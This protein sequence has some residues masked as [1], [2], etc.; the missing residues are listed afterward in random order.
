M[1]FAYKRLGPFILFFACLSLNTAYANNSL[2]SLFFNDGS[3]ITSKLLIHDKANWSVPLGPNELVVDE[4]NVKQH[5]NPSNIN[6]LHA[7][8]Y[9]DA[10][11]SSNTMDLKACIKKVESSVVTVKR[12]RGLGSGFMIHPDGYLITNSHVIAGS[13]K[14]TISITTYKKENNRLKLDVYKNVKI[15]A[16]SDRFD[17]A[18]LKIDTEDNEKFPF[19]SIAQSSHVAQG[20]EVFAIGSPNGFERSVTKGFVSVS[21]RVRDQGG[22]FQVLYIQHTAE[23]NPGNSGGPLF[24]MKGQVV[25][26][27]SLGSPTSDGMGFSV[28]SDFVRLFLNHHETFTYSAKNSASMYRYIAPPSVEKNQVNLVRDQVKTK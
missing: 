25:G 13:S 1:N 5:Q 10:I 27:N 22:L 9:F 21:K 4:K 20:D 26:V 19:V 14:D 23:I 28:V 15:I 2:Q 7:P 3:F 12:E 8:P 24:N 17:L 11:P 16:K 18:L 6:F